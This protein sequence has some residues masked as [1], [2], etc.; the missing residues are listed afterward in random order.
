MTARTTP[1][2]TETTNAD[3][4]EAMGHEKIAEGHALLAQARRKRT[5]P[6]ADAWLT[7]EA[8]GE[9]AKVQ[10][11]V[12]RDAGRRGEIEIEH[13]G[14]KPVVRRSEVERWMRSRRRAVVLETVET[15]PREAARAAVAARIA[16]AL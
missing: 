15:S 10:G 8:A 13:A 4:L 12:I 2:A 3:E 1:V 14:R 7:L 5:T 9:I 6:A 16:R 11:R